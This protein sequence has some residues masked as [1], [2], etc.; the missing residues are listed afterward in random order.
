LLSGRRER[1]LYAVAPEAAQPVVVAPVVVPAVVP[2]SV[3]APP[4]DWPV[5]SPV[6]DDE[7]HS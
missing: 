1:A 3:V 2:A 4:P 6:E 7:T 5:E